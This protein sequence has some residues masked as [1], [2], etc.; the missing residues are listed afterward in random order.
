[1]S[2]WQNE[3]ESV[4]RQAWEVATERSDARLHMAACRA[5]E[6]MVMDGFTMPADLLTYARQ[7][8]LLYDY[9]DRLQLRSTTLA[10]AG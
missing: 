6:A 3:A 8:R 9:L 1:M 10:T 2:E 5:I 7:T 4:I